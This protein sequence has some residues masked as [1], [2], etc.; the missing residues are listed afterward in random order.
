MSLMSLNVFA[1]LWYVP[2]GSQP[3]RVSVNDGEKKKPLR[4]PYGNR[5]G[6]TASRRSG[7]NNPTK[8]R[9]SAN[10]LLGSLL[11]LPHFLRRILARTE[12]SDYTRVLSHTHTI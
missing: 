1:C 3:T 12:K 5:T 11:V 10:F 8:L 9:A 4:F 2:R 6:G 7:G